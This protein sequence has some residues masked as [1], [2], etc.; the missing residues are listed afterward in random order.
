MKKGLSITR[1]PYP[2]NNELFFFIEDSNGS[3][4]PIKQTFSSVEGY[5]VRM[6]IEAPES[7]KIY[8]GE[9]INR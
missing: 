7:V 3:I 5:Q 1:A 4:I 9:L 2:D 8:R 6:N